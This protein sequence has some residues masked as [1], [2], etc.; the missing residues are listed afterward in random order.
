[1]DSQEQ[2]ADEERRAELTHLLEVRNIV[3]HRLWLYEKQEAVTRPNTPPNVLI[4]MAGTRKELRL[5][6]AKIRR[7][8]IDTDVL[9]AVGTDGLVLEVSDRVEELAIT[10]QAFIEHVEAMQE[11][12]RQAREARQAEVDTRLEAQDTTLEAHTTELRAQSDILTTI[13]ERGEAR[14]QRARQLKRWALVIGMLLITAILLY[15]FR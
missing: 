6:D 3:L 12:D 1:V 11:A 4:E 9:D 8:H 13:N 7:P 5:L 14:E 2:K 15:V 10:F